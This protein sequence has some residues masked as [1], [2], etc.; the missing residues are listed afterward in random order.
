MSVERHPNIH[1]VGFTMDIFSSFKDRLRGP[2]AALVNR[3]A[4]MTILSEE[5]TNFIVKVSTRLDDEIGVAHAEA[6]KQNSDHLDN[7]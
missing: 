7:T 4:A 2:A 5:I 3:Q 6:P 1:A